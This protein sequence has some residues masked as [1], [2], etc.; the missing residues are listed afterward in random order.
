[1]VRVNAVDILPTMDIFGCQILFIKVKWAGFRA[2]FLV[3][4]LVKLQSKG[5]VDFT[6][7]FFVVE[8]S[9]CRSTDILSVGH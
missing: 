5:F 8:V 6:T 9:K 2:K 7:A 4:G 1:M 3:D